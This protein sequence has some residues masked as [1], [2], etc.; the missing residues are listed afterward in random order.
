MANMHRVF[1]PDLKDKRAA[2]E[3]LIGEAQREGVLAIPSNNFQANH[4]FFQ[5]VMLAYNLWRWTKLLAGACDNPLFNP[6]R[7]RTDETKLRLPHPAP[8]RW[9]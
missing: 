4:A 5:F 3:N 2:A 1:V 7:A 9:D 8:A 6:G